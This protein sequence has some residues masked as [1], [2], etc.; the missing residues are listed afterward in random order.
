MSQMKL[1]TFVDTYRHY[2]SILDE[3]TYDIAYTVDSII[4]IWELVCL[5][6]FTSL[7]VR[8]KYS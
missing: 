7:S 8:M 1:S 4:I 3:D 6:F 5:L 2:K